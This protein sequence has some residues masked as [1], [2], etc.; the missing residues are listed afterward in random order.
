M[1]DEWQDPPTPSESIIYQL[2]KKLDDNLQINGACSRNSKILT[3]RRV[4]DIHR[5][6]IRNGILKQVLE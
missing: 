3:I 4:L 6:D 5:Q 2:S 1:Q